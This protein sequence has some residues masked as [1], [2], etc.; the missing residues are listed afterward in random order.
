MPMIG[1][2]NRQLLLIVL[3]LGI[4]ACS[5]TS[6]YVNEYLDPQTAATVTS[7]TKPLVFY[8]DNPSQAAYARNFL[9]LGP[10]AVN[11]GGSYRYYVWVSAW[12]TMQD[13]DMTEQRD[14]LE[15]LIVFAD[16]EPL[17][18]KLAGWT[19]DV[20]GVSESIYTR[21]VASAVDAYYEVTTDQIRL[22]SNAVNVRLSTGP[23]A[24]DNYE[25][26]DGQKSAR[27][28]LRAFLDFTFR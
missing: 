12:S 24:R 14:R 8:R 7:S 21:P 26:W 28:S 11:R 2:A 1:I 25:A 27:E 3:L 23:S 9:Q 18:L 13:A 6:R 22:I 4:A 5:S 15:S 20:I 17:I 10:V 16:A 19:P